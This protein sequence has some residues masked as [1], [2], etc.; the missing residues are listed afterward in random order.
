MPKAERILLQ[1]R[2]SAADK[3]RIKSLASKQGLTLQ[4]AVV[5]AFNAWA[6]E[7][8]TQGPDRSQTKTTLPNPPRPPNT[9]SPAS[10]EWLKQ[11]NQLDWTQC[12]EV[13]LL[14]DGVHQVL[15]LKDTDAPLS[16]VL[17]AV[18]DGLPP[19]EVVEIFDLEIP[20]LMKVLDFAG[21]PPVSNALN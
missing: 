18:A 4:K 1:V 10:W 9:E 13:E 21:A 15:V 17:R 3:R 20:Q 19:Y 14:E 2:L 11:A 12:P 16:Q 5:E 6:K 7:L 8:R